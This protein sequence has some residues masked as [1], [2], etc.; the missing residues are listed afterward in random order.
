M[1]S[2]GVMEAIFDTFAPEPGSE[3]IPKNP[4]QNEVTSFIS[5][6]W[7]HNINDFRERERKRENY[8]EKGQRDSPE[9]D[10]EMV[11]PKTQTD[12]VTPL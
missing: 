6:S 11:D 4:L 3:G 9:L 2:C 5:A 10:G 7:P 12:I 8:R 1:N